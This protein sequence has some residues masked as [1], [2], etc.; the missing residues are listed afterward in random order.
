MQIKIE[1]DNDQLNQIVTTDLENV[2]YALKADLKKVK[3]K[4]KGFVFSK[5]P[6]VDQEFLKSHIK[7]FETV[8]KYYSPVALDD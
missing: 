4:N 6:K 1:L 5:D 7:S 3:E 8:I 2:L